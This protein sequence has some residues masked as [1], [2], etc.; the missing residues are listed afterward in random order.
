MSEIFI[1]L[2]TSGIIYLYI[3]DWLH[4][5]KIMSGFTVQ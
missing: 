3:S 5:I 1:D 2:R 4:I